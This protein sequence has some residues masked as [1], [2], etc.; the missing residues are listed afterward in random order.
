MADNLDMLEITKKRR[1]NGEN[2]TYSSLPDDSVRMSRQSNR[3]GGAN[4]GEPADD[5]HF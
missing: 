1:A 2:G 3:S 4:V 5:P